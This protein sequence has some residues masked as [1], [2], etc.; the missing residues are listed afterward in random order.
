MKRMQLKSI[1]AIAALLL[2][3]ASL[4]VSGCT[5]STTNQ[6][7]SATPS[8]EKSA[9]PQVVANTQGVAND[10]NL[11][12]FLAGLKNQTYADTNQIV[13]AWN[14]TWKNNTSARLDYVVLNKTLNKTLSYSAT[15][16]K[17]PTTLAATNYI[18]AN[19]ES[20]IAQGSIVKGLN[21][22]Q[23]KGNTSIQ[24]G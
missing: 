16:I 15:Y 14:L 21:P 12:Q 1:I 5:T 3:V 22:V 17:F 6:T 23:I 24:T 2:V 7:P 4:S 20:V 10:A 11:E 8:E 13:K 9:S 18:K 19:P